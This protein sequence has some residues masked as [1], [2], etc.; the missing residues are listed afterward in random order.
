MSKYNEVDLWFTDDGDIDIAANGDLK[1]TEKNFG[2]AIIQEIRDRLNARRGEWRLNANIGS[3]LP[4]FLGESATQKNLEQIVL[5]IERALTFDRMLSPSELEI[6]PLQINDNIAIFRII[7]HTQL[8]EITVHLGY[9]S[10]IQRFI[11]Y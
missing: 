3:N 4:S 1:S 9:D 6:I 8:Q 7:I 11:G 2:R 10:N 5:E